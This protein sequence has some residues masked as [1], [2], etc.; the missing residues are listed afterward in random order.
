MGCVLRQEAGSSPMASFD[1]TMEGPRSGQ[2]P[3][4]GQALSLSPPCP[5]GASGSLCAWV[6]SKGIIKCHLKQQHRSFCP[7]S[8]IS[9][10]HTQ[11]RTGTTFKA[12]TTTTTT[13]VPAASE[14]RWPALE[15]GSEAFTALL[16][17]LLLPA[18]D[19]AT[20]A[21]PYSFQD[22]FSLDEYCLAFVPGETLALI[23]AYDHSVIPAPSAPT[24]EQQQ[25]TSTTTTPNIVFV[26]QLPALDNACGTIALIHA[27]LNAL[28]PSVIPSSSLLASLVPPG[29]E[30]AGSEEMGV[31][32][33]SHEAIHAA[34]WYVYIDG[35]L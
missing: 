16:Q 12:M 28:P 27:A 4:P 10:P 22:V 20:S 25:P 6:G 21:S 26:K 2:P 19:A 29:G 1:T 24:T 17:K 8:R 14:D 31:R 32:L 30:G 34:H 11:T 13:D 23:L 18:S 3:P 15:S 7:H 5:G 9:P 35:D 33:D